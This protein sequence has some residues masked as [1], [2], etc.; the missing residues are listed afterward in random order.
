MYNKSHRLKLMTIVKNYSSTDNLYLGLITE[1]SKDKNL[2]V[3][4]STNGYQWMDVLKPLSG[5]ALL[6]Y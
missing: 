5:Y 3:E 4:I 2:R 1:A 6:R